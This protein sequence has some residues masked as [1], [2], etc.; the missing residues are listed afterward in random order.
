MEIN[1]DK[2]AG[3]LY[4]SF[5]NIRDGE[6]EETVEINNYNDKGLEEN[7]N[8]LI[9]YDKNGKLLGIEIISSEIKDIEIKENT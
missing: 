8:V 6:V 4:I 3:A 9:D 7:S 5:F 1:I 2:E